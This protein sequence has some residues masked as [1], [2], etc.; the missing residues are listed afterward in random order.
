M[1]KLKLIKVLIRC[2][3][4]TL[5]I[6]AKND[7]DPDKGGLLQQSWAKLTTFWN[8]IDQFYPNNEENSVLFGT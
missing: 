7:T 5:E 1:N 8:R 2:A 6:I 3:S 4:H